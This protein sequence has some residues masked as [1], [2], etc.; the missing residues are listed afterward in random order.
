MAS[1]SRVGQ[2]KLPN[3]LFAGR[4]KNKPFA[5]VRTLHTLPMK[6]FI[7]RDNANGGRIALACDAEDILAADRLFELHFARKPSQNIGVSV[8]ETVQIDG[9]CVLPH[10]VGEKYLIKL[11]PDRKPKAHKIKLDPSR[12]PSVRLFT[13]T[14]PVHFYNHCFYCGK[15]MTKEIRTKDHV[16]PRSQGGRLKVPCCKQCN[17]LKGQL[18]LE[19]YR[20]L[21]AYRNGLIPLDILQQVKFKGEELAEFEIDP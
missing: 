11:A 18:K 15:L 20:V 14:T 10:S 13:S 21:V 2:P 19:E 3:G 17:M 12:I 6:H 8:Q 7:Y 1:C 16:T 4:S 5:T 9:V